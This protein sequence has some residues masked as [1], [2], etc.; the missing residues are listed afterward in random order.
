MNTTKK[1]IISFVL[2]FLTSHIVYIPSIFSQD[3]DKNLKKAISLM[4]K[5]N[6]QDAIVIFEDFLSKHPEH[7]VAIYNTAMCNLYLG[8]PDIA[9][10]HL[11]T[12][13]R[14]NQQDA[15][16]YN[17]LGLALERVGETAKAITN[18]TKSIELEKNYY[19][20]YFNRGRCYYLTNKIQQAKSDISFSKK[21]KFINPDLYLLS[22][23]I[24]LETKSFNAAI[25][26]FKTIEKYK[27]DNPE[28]L[29]MLAEAYFK[30]N[31]HEKSIQCYNKIL[32]LQ[33]DDINALNNRSLCYHN[34]GEDEK[35]EQ[36]KAKINEIQ[37]KIG[38]N[39]N[40]LEFRKL[41]SADKSFSIDIPEKWRAFVSSGDE[42]N[43]IVFFNPDFPN[44]QAGDTAFQCDFGGE[45][46]YYPHYFTIDTAS[47]VNTIQ[48]RT[49]KQKEYIKNRKVEREKMF[50][51]FKERMR[52]TFNANEKNAREL[53]K[54][55]YIDSVI[56]KEFYGIEYSIITTSGKLIC[57]YLW[58]P[59]ENSFEYEAVLD[60]IQSSLQINE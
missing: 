38:I 43:V 55:N 30:T 58:I 10:E 51:N 5:S 16:A 48:L 27:K 7:L 21:N 8:R 57:L 31:N 32:K 60:R 23:K 1:I 24:N 3:A 46:I 28:Y 59:N 29:A 20:A 40:L 53:V 14:K 44:T 26:D 18:Y 39:P 50:T 11:Y 17:L 49:Y 33:P 13:I 37:Q 19:E 47:N 9:V 12:F 4:E 36:D 56:G 54:S 41:V 52:K 42:M 34:L 45:I 6:F 2:L 35:A 25:E 15:D 22:G